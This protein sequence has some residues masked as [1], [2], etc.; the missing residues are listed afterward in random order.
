MKRNC[1][2]DVLTAAALVLSLP[3]VRAQ[4]QNSDLSNP[5]A[6]TFDS[7]GNLFVA[8]YPNTIIKFSSDGTKSTFATGVLGSSGLS[9]DNAG[10]LLVLNGDFHSIA[11][12]TPDGTKSIFATNIRNPQGLGCDRAGNLFVSEVG[13]ESILRFTPNGTKSTV[14]TGIRVPR[15]M[16]FDGSGN[17]F[18]YDALTNSIFK[19]APDGTKSEFSAGVSALNLIFD[20]AGNLLVGDLGS[21]SVIKFAPNGS[22]TTFVA[23]IPGPAGL[24]FDKAGNLFVSDQSTNSIFKFAP[25]GAKTVFYKGPSQPGAAEEEEKDSSAGLPEKYAKDYLIASGTISPDEKFAVIYPTKDNEEF[26]GG[27]NYVVALKPF[28][29][30]EKLNTKWPYFKNE[31]HG[32]VNADW[33]DDSS[34][35]LITLDGKWGPHDIFLVEFKDGKLSRTTNLLAKMHDVLL[36]DYRKAKAERY[37]EYFDFIFESEDNPICKLD[38]NRQVRIDALATTDPKGG[39]DE[40]VWEGRLIATWDVAQANFT[41]RKVTR[42]FAGV[43]KH[44]D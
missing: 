31:S 10:I 17:L 27:A 18:V 6:L 28:A 38:G 12:F 16:A 3:V 19:I 14:A 13:T 1:F 42:V 21:Q 35:A 40:R 7:S 30:L 5:T 2:T 22:K 20:K 33:S 37:N 11:K 44:E 29:I 43:R 9:F 23:G 39:G 32:G 15:N 34:V 25:D 4:Q 26:P 41:S 24:A 36:S 8:S